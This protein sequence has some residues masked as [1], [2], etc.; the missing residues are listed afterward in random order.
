MIIL[1]F[2]KAC[3]LTSKKSKGAKMYITGFCT[4]LNHE[5]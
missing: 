2:Q 1:K 3:E 5:L 4:K